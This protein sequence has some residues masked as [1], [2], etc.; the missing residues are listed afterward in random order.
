MGLKAVRSLFPLRSAEHVVRLFKTELDGRREPDLALLSIVLGY[1]EHLLTVRLRPSSV[2]STCTFPQVSLELV[3]ALKCRFESQ[4]LSA[5]DVCSYA[6]GGRALVSR[7]SDVIWNTLNRSYNKDRAHIQSLYSYLTGTKL[8]AFGVAFSVVAACQVLGLSDVHLA[9]S[10]DHAWLMF[11]PDG[12]ETTEVTWHG[13]GNEDK[14]GQSVDSGVAEKMW[15]YLNGVCVRCDRPMEVACMVT[16]INPALDAHTDSQ[17][18]CLLQ[19]SLLWLLYDRGHLDKYPVALGTL[20][21]LEDIERTPGRPEPLVLY[22]QAITSAKRYYKNQHVYP[23]LYLAG[24]HQRLRQ[25]QSALNAWA[26]ATAVVQNYNY[27]REDEEIYKEF[28][29]IA[30]DIIPNLLKE[31]ASVGEETD[32]GT[33][34]KESGGGPCRPSALQDAWTFAHLLNFYDGICKWEEG[35]TTPVLHV[36]WANFLVQS[37]SRFDNKVRMA[38][39]LLSHEVETDSDETRDLP[40]EA[41]EGRASRKKAAAV[42]RRPSEENS[43]SVSKADASKADRPSSKA[44]GESPSGDKSAIKDKLARAVNDGPTVTLHSEKMKCMKELFVAPKLNT[45]AIKLQLTAQS[46]VQMGKRGKAAGADY[47]TV[48]GKRQRKTVL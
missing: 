1:V 5:V 14:R 39:T 45:S 30:N 25:L 8:D 48:P 36:G 17:E 13:K 6:P 41:G 40:E 38:V 46:Q 7:V 31:A 47:G 37:L 22:Q 18:L 29:D 26:Q 34:P 27:N 33:E 35:S 32:E 11:G 9:L 28:F 15:L 44:G 10:E 12:S 16:A 43:S 23:Y 21:D 20:A 3:E 42:A 24:Y 2:G 19:Q 4:V